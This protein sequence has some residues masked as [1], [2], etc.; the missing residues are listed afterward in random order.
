M[1]ALKILQLASARGHL[2]SSLIVLQTWTLLS[3]LGAVAETERHI[4]FLTTSI[5]LEPR[6]LKIASTSYVRGSDLK[7]VFVYLHCANYVLKKCVKCKDMKQRENLSENLKTLLAEAYHLYNL[8]LPLPF[9]QLLAWFN[10]PKIWF[11]MGC[12]LQST[13]FGVLLAEDSFYQSWVR[14]P[15]SEESLKRIVQSL[16]ATNRCDGIREVMER[17]ILKCRWNVLVRQTLI[18]MDMK[19]GVDEDGGWRFRFGQED[20]MI[21]KI[22]SRIRLVLFKKRWSTTV[23]GLK[24]K[25]KQFLFMLEKSTSLHQAQSVRRLRIIITSWHDFTVTMLVLKKASAVKIQAQWRRKW[26]K[27]CYNWA[28]YRVQRTNFYFF[29]LSM[30]RFNHIRSKMLGRWRRLRIQVERDR[31]AD[32]LLDTL[33]TNGQSNIMHKAMQRILKVIQARKQ[34]CRLLVWTKWTK[35]Y[36]HRR[37][38]HARA[39]IR[40]FIREIFSRVEE[41]KQEE[42][43]LNAVAIVEKIAL[44]TKYR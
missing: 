12:E 40:F 22:Q 20:K 8:D 25:R 26:A 30:M 38:A 7:L 42:M 16:R 11:D 17:A 3:R 33:R 18:N 10:S 5:T 23:V 36:M 14:D 29:Q 4:Y 27:H 41:R 19:K 28:N 43:M 15:L 35:C 9:N 2:E 34:S 6:S 32:I 39:T 13:C 21:A 44:N 24:A 1:S 37:R 31:S